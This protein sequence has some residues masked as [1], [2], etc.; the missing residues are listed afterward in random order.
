MR[1][2]IITKTA[3]ELWNIDLYSLEMI[4]KFFGVSRQAVRKYL[5]NH[6]VDTSSGGIRSVQC[7]GC[8][9]LFDKPRSQIRNNRH[10]YCCSDCRD[11]ALTNPK[12][13]MNRQAQIKA[14]D[15]VG[16]Q[17][18]LSPT[19]VVYFKDHDQNNPKL[20]NLIV[21][22]NHADCNRYI[23]VGEKNAGVKVLWP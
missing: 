20:S 8:G 19:D 11:S 7:G 22:A 13:E 6:G 1:K 4:A 10:N 23:R 15:S 9:N 14:R 18:S 2:P 16:R 5:I 3:I 12:H 17:Y 21:F